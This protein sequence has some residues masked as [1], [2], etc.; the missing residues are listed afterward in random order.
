MATSK[1]TLREG[2]VGT[3]IEINHPESFKIGK[4]E[5]FQGLSHIDGH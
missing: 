5:K 3:Y 2:H 4:L 1:T